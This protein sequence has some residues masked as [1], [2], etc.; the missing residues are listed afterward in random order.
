MGNV[1]V[2]F[3]AKDESE[4]NRY[5]VPLKNS[6]VMQGD[7]KTSCRFV[8]GNNN[9]PDLLMMGPF[10]ER[11]VLAKNLER[12][13]IS[14]LM[15]NYCV[16][17]AGA[18][19]SC[20]LNDEDS[21]EDYLRTAKVYVLTHWGGGT[22]ESILAGEKWHNKTV[23]EDAGTSFFKNWFFFSLSS[24]RPELFD[25]GQSS[26]QIYLPMGET[27]VKFVTDL[28]LK[29]YDFSQRDYLLA[30]MLACK[31][32]TKRERRSVIEAINKTYKGISLPMVIKK[33]RRKDVHGD[34]R[35]IDI[36]L[37]ESI[38]PNSEI[39]EICL[40]DLETLWKGVCHEA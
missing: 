14:Q 22:R 3:V 29:A 19:K 24:E 18:I 34:R 40:Q 25:L 26:S 21:L 20:F 13:D 32:R 27:L 9:V 10:E 7:Y 8:V 4:F 28:D 15:R 12:K 37:D 17:I 1:C 30:L 2:V 5:P 38:S 36:V 23:K 33:I 6:G 11:N 16:H 31:C 39:I 35:M